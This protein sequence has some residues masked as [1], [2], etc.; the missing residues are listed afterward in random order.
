MSRRTLP[1]IS[2]AFQARERSRLARIRRALRLAGELI[3][4]DDKAGE[5]PARCVDADW[6]QAEVAYRKAETVEEQHAAAAAVIWRCHECP[7]LDLCEEWAKADRYSG[8]AAGTAFS[9]GKE[10]GTLRPRRAA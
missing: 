5:I 3:G 8:L 2:A 4:L 10:I 7:V 9:D 6:S 1:A